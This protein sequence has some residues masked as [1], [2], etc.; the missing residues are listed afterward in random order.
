MGSGRSPL[1]LPQPPT[2]TARSVRSSAQSISSS[3]LGGKLVGWASAGT[4][5]AEQ[6]TAAD[7][8]EILGWLRDAAVHVWL[9]GGW[10]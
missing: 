4:L 2:S 8:V 1:A 3:D 5:V 7:V 6:V 10:V 9:D